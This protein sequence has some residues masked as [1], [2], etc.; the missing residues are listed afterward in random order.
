MPCPDCSA[1][2]MDFV[3]SFSNFFRI[4]VISCVLRFANQMMRGSGEPGKIRRK[5]MVEQAEFI[6]RTGRMRLHENRWSPCGGID[7]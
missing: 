2:P 7:I 6:Q 1:E 4:E 5:M 3:A